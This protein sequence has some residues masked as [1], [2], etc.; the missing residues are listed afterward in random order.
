MKV[1]SKSLFTGLGVLLLVTWLSGPGLGQMVRAQDP[2]QEAE[3]MPELSPVELA[4]GEKLKV[5][6]TTTILGDVVAQV[7]GDRIDLTVLMPLGADLHTYEPVPADAAAV[8]DA[9]VMFING[10]GVEEAFLKNFDTGP[11]LAIVPAAVGIQV[12]EVHAHKHGHEHAMGDPHVWFDVQN[13]MIWVENI[14]YAL[15]KL[16]PAGAGVYSENAH[17]C[18]YELDELDA[19]IMKEVA[20][21]PRENRKIVTNHEAF[22]YFSESYGFELVGSVLPVTT[23]AEPSARDLAALEENIKEAGAKVIF[24]DNT[25]NPNL[26]ERVAEDTG[27]AVVMLYTGSLGPEGSGAENYLDY[28]R[29]D[30]TAIVEALK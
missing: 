10:L 11:A 13:V 7:G 29:Y 17:S 24:V 1:R 14:R 19:W 20:Q 28:M 4:E 2:A 15:S 8:S 9:Q 12:R 5:V 18:L 6:A 26:A 22:S 30:V 27:I 25:V 3:V 23:A 21:V 16:D